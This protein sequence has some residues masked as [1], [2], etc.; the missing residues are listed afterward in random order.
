MFF[1]GYLETFLEKN[2]I[3]YDADKMAQRTLTR[4]KRI[5]EIM[6]DIF[7]SKYGVDME[8][9]KLGSL[10]MNSYSFMTEEQIDFDKVLYNVSFYDKD[11][12]K[13]D[14][15]N[16]DIMNGVAKIIIKC[17]D[18]ETDYTNKNKE[19]KNEIANAIGVDEV[20]ISGWSRVDDNH[21]SIT[22]Y[23]VEYI[24]DTD[25]LEGFD[26]DKEYKDIQAKAGAYSKTQIESDQEVER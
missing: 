4:E 6:K 21:I 2:N 22:I 20:D 3:S 19:L 5:R 16:F 15:I 10:I 11:S 9:S 12:V 8:D 24:V 26:C 17:K 18:N 23:A 13:I 14:F 1:S 25:K 7:K